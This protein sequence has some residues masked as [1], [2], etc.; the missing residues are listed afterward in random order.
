MDEWEVRRRRV[1]Y[2]GPPF[3]EVALEEVRLPDGRIV[4]DYHQIAAG[5]FANI[6]AETTAGDILLLRQY[7]HG[8]RRVALSVPGGRIEAGE[9]ALAAAQRELLEE[10]GYAAESWRE[11]AGY[12]LSCSY[13]FAYHHFFHAVGLNFRAAPMSDDLETSEIVFMDRARVQAALLAG[14][15]S[16]IGHALPLA[17]VL[18]GA[19]GGS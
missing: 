4:D 11:L 6:V 17:M 16:S 13:G 9:L 8:I 18:L 19:P 1:V 12:Y 2:S 10:T 5:T 3:L 14:E 7:R 15:L